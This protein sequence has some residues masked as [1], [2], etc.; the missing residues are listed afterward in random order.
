LEG[1]FQDEPFYE[2]GEYY[3]ELGSDEYLE[4]KEQYMYETRKQAVAT[5]K[6]PL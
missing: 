6:Y 2:D 1:E 3:N 5:R 4:D